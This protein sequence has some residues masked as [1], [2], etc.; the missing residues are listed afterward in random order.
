MVQVM[1]TSE[2]FDPYQNFKFRVKWDGRARRC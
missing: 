2:G 1:E